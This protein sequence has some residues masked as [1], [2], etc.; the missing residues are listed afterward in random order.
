MIA[1]LQPQ[2]RLHLDALAAQVGG[3]GI[4]PGPTSPTS[5]PASRRPTAPRPS[6]PAWTRSTGLLILSA[7]MMLRHMGWREAADLVIK[8]MEAPSA[9]K[10]TYDFA[11][12]MDGAT[13]LSCSAFGDA[14]IARM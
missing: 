10:V 13:E 11:R 6:T 1:T 5:T 2:R 14:M 8:A 7:E 3:I 12:L 4:A 9:T